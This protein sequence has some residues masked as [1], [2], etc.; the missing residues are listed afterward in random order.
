M[1]N[2]GDAFDY[3]V[4]DCKVELS[5]FCSFFLVSGVADAFGRGTPKYIAGMS[6]PELAEIVLFKTKGQVPEARIS[7]SIDK[8]PEYWSGW[9]LAY[10]QWYTGRSFAELYDLGITTDHL[11]NVYPTLHEADITRFVTLANELIAKNERGR[12]TKLHTIR[13]AAGLTQKAL[14]EAAD[15]NIRMVQLYEQRNKDI[16]KAS[17]ASLAKLA[18]V[19]G[20]SVEDLLESGHLYL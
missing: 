9:I 10:Y 11:L 13:K 15:V 7:R 2:L 20:C 14:A 19:L 5:D 8:S 17:A 1:N 4:Y 16:N 12:S 18:H 3:A 6:G